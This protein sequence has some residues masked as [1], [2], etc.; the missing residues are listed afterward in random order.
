MECCFI[1]TVDRVI[2]IIDDQNIPTELKKDKI[3][4][5][6]HGKTWKFMLYE[7]YPHLR[8]ARYLAV[9]YDSADDHAVEIIN[10][11][12]VLI[13]EGRYQEAHES[14]MKVADDARAFNSIGVSLMMQGRFE[15]AMPWFEKA[16]EYDHSE[17][18]N[19]IDAINAEYRYENDQKAAIEEYLKKFE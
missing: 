12:N 17:A 14:L 5:I 6:D 7:I 19:N 13:R 1:Y 3:K 4:W 16:L 8:C 2:V 10:Q 18:Q 11:S 9:Y 15:E